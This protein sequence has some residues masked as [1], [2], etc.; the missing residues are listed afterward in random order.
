M[1]CWGSSARRPSSIAAPRIARAL[2]R[3]GRKEVAVQAFVSSLSVE[4]LEEEELCLFRD[5]EAFSSPSSSVQEVTQKPGGQAT[6]RAVPT[7]SY[8]MTDFALVDPHRARKHAGQEGGARAPRVYSPEIPRPVSA[9]QQRSEHPWRAPPS[10]V[11]RASEPG[12]DRPSGRWLSVLGGE[13]RTET[14]GPQSPI[15]TEDAEEPREC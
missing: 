2:S 10:L 12:S 3:T 9:E 13:S 7:A 6:R 11:L 14:S 8:P 4:K 5:G 15:S 1:N